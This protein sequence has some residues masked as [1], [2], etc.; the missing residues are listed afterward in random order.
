MDTK[1]IDWT[2]VGGL[3]DTISD[4]IC[5][6]QPKTLKAAIELARMKDEQLQ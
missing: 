2:Y 3:K 5:V 1:G 6:F 4:G